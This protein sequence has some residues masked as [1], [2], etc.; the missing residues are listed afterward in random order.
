MPVVLGITFLGLLALPA[1]GGGPSVSASAHAPSAVAAPVAPAAGIIHGDLVVAAGHSYT[2][3]PTPGQSIYFQGGNITVDGTLYITNVTLSFVEFV[4]PSGT[5]VQRLYHIL[6]FVDDGTVI[7][8]NST[9]T[10]DM[11]SVNAYAKLN[12]TI[13]AGASM[14]LAA[15][16]L[17]FPGWVTVTGA[18]ANLTLSEHSSIRNNPA[19][20]GINEPKVLKGDNNFAPRLLV[21]KGASASLLQSTYTNLYGD[22]F[23]A[24]G[25]PRPDP[26]AN[27]HVTIAAGTTTSVTNLTTGN[28][29]ANL[30]LDWAYPS[31]ITGGKV[32]VV[33]TDGNGIPSTSVVNLTYGVTKYSLGTIT[34]KNDTFAGTASVPFSAGLNAAIKAGGLYQ[35]LNYTGAFGGL[36]NKISL[37]FDT[38][39]PLVKNTAVSV[40]LNPPVSNNLTVVGTGS[41]LT[42]IDTEI[43]LTFADLPSGPLSL[44][45]VVPWN[46]HKA[47]FLDGASGY[48]ANL[49]VNGGL[50]AVFRASAVYADATSTA[51]LFRWAEF[52]LTGLGGVLLNGGVATAHY[53]YETPSQNNQTA[54]NLD[55]NLSTVNPVLSGYVQRWDSRHAVAAY[56]ASGVDGVATLL[57]ASNEITA[58]SLPDGYFLGNYHVGV[59]VS[60][61]P[62]PAQAFKSFNWSN[63][64]SYPIGVASGTPNWGQPDRGPGVNFPAYFDAVAVP[65]GGITFTANGTAGTTVRIGQ[66]LAAAVT[67]DDEGTAPITQLN[68]TLRYNAS[69][70][71]F[72][73][74]QD[75][76]VD[77]RAAGAPASFAVSWPVND[78][79]TG[80]NGKA[81]LNPFEFQIVWNNGIATEGGGTLLKTSGVT[82][83]PS[84]VH[85]TVTSPTLPSSLSG[86]KTVSYATT[87]KV[88][89]NGSQSA[90]IELV[91]FPSHGHGRGTTLFQVLPTPNDSRLEQYVAFGATWNAHTLTPGV[92]YTLSLLVS[93]NGVVQNV[94]LGVHA[95]PKPSGP[96]F[97]FE[98]ILGEPLW[99]WLAITAAVILGAIGFILFS[100]RQAAGKVVEC[101]ECGN[102]IPET[103]KV[104][105]KC[106]AEFEAD[107]VRC[108][109]CSSTIPGTSQ[110]L[111]GVRGAAARQGRGRG[112]RPAPP[113]VRRLHGAVPGRGEE[114]ARRQLQRGLVLGLVEAPVVVHAVQPVEAPA[115]PGDVPHRDVRA[116]ARQPPARWPRCCWQWGHRPPPEGTCP[117]TVRPH[118]AARRRPGGLGRRH[119]R[120]PAGRRAP[121][122]A[123]G[124]RG[125]RRAEAVPELR[126]GDP[127]RVPRLS[128]LR[129][130][131]AVASDPAPKSAGGPSP[132]ASAPGPAGAFMPHR[133]WQPRSRWR[134]TLRSAR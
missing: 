43:G 123:H 7:V 86:S 31:G 105:P 9:I 106:G 68:V 29:S 134:A 48:L 76:V 73:G 79:V 94:S 2:I 90:T 13:N 4:G 52:N 35:Y 60:T 85:P 125:R 5:P 114:G 72:L 58:L 14:A 19:V 122:G 42:T 16:S 57:L 130:G 25:T 104:C 46:S 50:N 120:S 101:G 128:V 32:A 132:P 113:G 63:I 34:F 39:G 36:P 74:E 100:R 55:N 26:L 115:G 66:L 116:P 121:S 37:S 88:L 18:G 41:R 33:Y 67:I 93:Y 69:H 75:K 87:G 97:P 6:H 92:S 28:D 20:N 95:V 78:T 109:R 133:P 129:V 118:A 84:D 119:A 44:G 51:Y 27:P 70:P 40:L 8:T 17:A 54:N 22:N 117:Q 59:E 12:L 49:S 30:S 23:T 96:G 62:V 103:A 82:V 65:S 45:P 38:T 15:S 11:A 53:A 61:I 21:A 107:V 91:A 81:I 89:Y 24:N 71:V 77:L 56:G 110:V 112:L 131:D 83:A 64:S 3:A 80:L 127:A 47:A 126:Q 10:T 99:L 102:L 1:F 108:S 111:S 98:K 124:R